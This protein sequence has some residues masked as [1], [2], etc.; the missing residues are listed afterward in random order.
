MSVRATLWVLDEVE[1]INT[2]EFAVLVAL[3]DDANDDGLSCYPSI[4][5]VAERARMSVSGARQVIARLESKGLI[6]VFRP[7]RQGRGQHNRYGLCM[8]G[9]AAE[10]AEWLGAESAPS[11]RVQ[12]PT[13]SD[14]TA[15]RGATTKGSRKGRGRVHSE[16]ANPDPD[17]PPGL[18][19][20]DL[21][22]KGGD[23]EPDRP[24]GD[25]VIEPD[26]PKRRRTD[27]GAR[28]PEPW[29]PTDSVRADLVASHPG[30]DIEAEIEAFCDYWWAEAGQK[31]RKLDWDRALRTWIRRKQG[32]LAEQARRDGRLDE[33]RRER[34]SAKKSSAERR[35][36][37][38][39]Y[40]RDLDAVLASGDPDELIRHL[41][42]TNSHERQRSEP[43]DRPGLCAVAEH[44]TG[45]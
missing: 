1:G 21:P 22:P 14:E 44:G 32:D 31:S 20:F 4:R 26:P 2:S 7:E 15:P 25:V 5:R 10:V 11:R 42:E 3:A 30:I 40:G 33:Y 39:E 24:I 38:H 27:R 35:A 28:L 6:V 13:P 29:E 19:T 43:S 34:D 12:I 17:I 36:D 41:K 23:A 8:K 16:R 9:D 18:T 37:R 45:P